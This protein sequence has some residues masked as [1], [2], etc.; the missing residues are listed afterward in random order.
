MFHSIEEQAI[1]ARAGEAYD[2]F[3]EIQEQCVKEARDQEEA[4]Q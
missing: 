3:V 2:R 1:F 4:E